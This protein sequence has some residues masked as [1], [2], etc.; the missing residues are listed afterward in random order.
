MTR[1][2]FHSEVAE[3]VHFACRLLRKAYRQ[4]HAVLVTAPGET[5]RSLDVALWTFDAQGFIPHRRVASDAVPES[6]L[7]RTPIW[8]AEDAERR[9]CPPVL[10][11]LGAG[12]ASQL[13]AFERVVEIVGRGP[14]EVQGA[15]GRWREYLARG[16]QPAHRS[17]TAASGANP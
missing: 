11:N 16:L 6:D 3:P 5:L 15:R 12:V 10:V 1:V 7:A 17:S 2:E 13:E 8:L 14:D 4:G 9:P